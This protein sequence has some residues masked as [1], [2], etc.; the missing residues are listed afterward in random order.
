MFRIL[1]C[2]KCGH[3]IAGEDSFVENIMDQYFGNLKIAEHSSN[4]KRH[5]LLAENGMLRSYFK[6]ILHWQNESIQRRDLNRAKI[7][8]LNDYI[9]K[10]NLIPDD[11][12]F[13]LYDQAEEHQ[14]KMQEQASKELQRLYGEFESICS[15]RSKADSTANMVIRKITKGENKK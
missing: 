10:H 1:R 3:V 11:I 6:Q 15:N 9:R 4:R 8:I 7:K 14:K 2:L 5:L 12:L 13:G